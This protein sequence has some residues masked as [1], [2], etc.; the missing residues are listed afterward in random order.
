MQKIC[1]THRGR[2]A[3]LILYGYSCTIVDIQRSI[4]Y[5]KSYQLSWLLSYW[6]IARQ[7][8]W[9]IARASPYSK[10]LLFIFSCSTTK[11]STFGFN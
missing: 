9:L 4:I 2:T 7:S 6:V 1:K 3:N 11:H 8:F 5:Q 10:Y